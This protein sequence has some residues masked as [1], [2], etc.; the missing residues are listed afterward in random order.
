VTGT[1]KIEATLV[2]FADG[3]VTLKRTDGKEVTLPLAK[4]SAEDRAFV[5]KQAKPP[6]PFE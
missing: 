3:K 5:E 1:Y 4:L 6:N 2:S